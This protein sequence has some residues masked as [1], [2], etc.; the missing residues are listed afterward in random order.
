MIETN[1]IPVVDIFAGPGGLSEG[2]VSYTS[3]DSNPF[4]AALSVEKDETSNKTLLIR[5]LFR[6]FQQDKIPDDYY[7]LLRGDISAEVFLDCYQD[8]VEVA[9]KKVWLAELGT[10]DF[11]PKLANERIA[12]AIGEKEGWV[13][14]G[15]PPCQAYSLVGR[16]RNKGVE[17][18]DSGTDVRN[19]LYVEFLQVLA[20]HWPPVFILENVKGLL[21]A[22]VKDKRILTQM[23]ADLERPA[24]AIAREDRQ[25]ENEGE[26]KEYTIHSLVKDTSEGFKLTDFI[27]RAEDYGIPQARHR[28][29]L[30]GIRNDLNVKPLQMIPST[31][32]TIGDVIGDL[33]SIRSGISNAKDSNQAWVECI[34]S[35]AESPWYKVLKSSDAKVHKAIQ[36]VVENIEVP[37]L[38]RGANYI[39]GSFRPK[40]QTR[41]YR[42]SALKGIC[43]HISRA[44]ME[45]DLHRYLFA[46]AYS[47]VHG[48]PPKLPQFP[49]ELLPEHANVASALE[50]EGFFSDR[51]K[52]QL[53]NRPGSTITSHM[54]KDGHYFIHPDP[55]QC[56]SLTVREA[57]RIQT[58]PDNYFFAGKRT[59][60]YSQIGNAVPP[61][62]ARQ[63]AE[64]V[65]DVL[66]K[67]GLANG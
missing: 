18:Y 39:P 45:S 59:S 63:I 47:R 46:T 25:I 13:L 5:S 33:P 41:Y 7:G 65:L 58:F 44:H 9:R 17:G 22:S 6:K 37:P 60:Q 32:V 10:D 30:M 28:V 21:S 55:Y 24:V 11:P 14:I 34:K 61:L 48:K 35:I 23:I 50:K 43:N 2:F 67:V 42:D 20:D 36:E 26:S 51:F 8:E 3:S 1:P 27:I 64:V 49:T 12:A 29:I 62:L 53:A 57:A 66:T 52:V 31:K 54:A 38:E 19:T 16:S 56:R 15:G 4:S 40:Y